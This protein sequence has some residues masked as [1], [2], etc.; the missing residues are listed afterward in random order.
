M[1]FISNL[2]SG[3]EAKSALLP[4]M[5]NVFNLNITINQIISLFSQP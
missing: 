3:S 1:V 5:V 2:L 4:K